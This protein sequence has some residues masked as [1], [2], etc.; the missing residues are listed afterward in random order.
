[1]RP[2]SIARWMV[3]TFFSFDDAVRDLGL[4]RSE[5]VLLRY[6][7]ET[8]RTLVQNVPEAHR[9]DELETIIA[10]LRAMLR[11]VDSSLVDEWEKMQGLEPVSQRQVESER[12]YDLAE[13]RRGLTIR[14]RTE[15]HR[16]L[17]ALADRNWEGA[18]QLVAPGWEAEEIE[19]AMAPYFEEWSSIDLSP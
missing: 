8:Y 14:V 11:D 17:K 9:D 5:G 1:I 18:S 16:L 6:L 2:K 4:Q 3:E 7:S 13:D 10:H 19:A 15:L 12:P